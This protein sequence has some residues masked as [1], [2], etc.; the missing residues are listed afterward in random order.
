MQAQLLSSIIVVVANC[1]CGPSPAVDAHD[2][3]LVPRDPPPGDSDDRPLVG[4]ASVEGERNCAE[5]CAEDTAELRGD[6]GLEED[7]DRGRLNDDPDRGRANDASGVSSS[8]GAFSETRR[9]LLAT[10]PRRELGGLTISA[11]GSSRTATRLSGR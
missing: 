11:G 3:G 6:V 2:S 1:R 5:E 8:T 9:L 7:S 10:L 4:S